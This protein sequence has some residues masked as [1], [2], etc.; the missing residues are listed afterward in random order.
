LPCP[1]CSSNASPVDKLGL[2]AECH[3][4]KLGEIATRLDHVHNN[5][6]HWMR[7]AESR[8]GRTIKYTADLP[9]DAGTK[10]DNGVAQGFLASGKNFTIRANYQPSQAVRAFL[11][12]T[13]TVCECQGLMLAVLYNALLDVLSVPVFDLVF[14]GIEIKT[15][16]KG[17]EGPIAD[18]V[19]EVGKDESVVKLGDWMYVG[20]RKK[21]LM[22]EMAMDGRA[23]AAAGGWNL[24]CVDLGTPKRYMGLGL[25]DK[26]LQI[27]NFSLD[28]IKS[29]MTG[30]YKPPA[31]EMTR[32][33]TMAA[34][35]SGRKIE[36]AS[37]RNTKN[38]KITGMLPEDV[39]IESI[40]R[41][42]IRRLNEL[43][44]NR[45]AL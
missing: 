34:L 40:R 27:D 26:Q 32:Q 38:T 22:T 5:I 45:L 33:E 6:I 1:R 43:I 10:R 2:C 24:I 37:S 16:V 35:L 20:N 36:S 7:E 44:E 18:L 17:P 29:K 25:I 30:H 8:Y 15:S 13:E 42:S 41:L 28:D 19:R 3:K 11:T 14:A 4:K 12:G 23:E 31:K 21:G 9:L 39:V